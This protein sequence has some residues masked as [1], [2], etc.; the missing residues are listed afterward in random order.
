MKCPLCNA[1]TEIKDT[2][3]KKDNTVVRKRI[4]FNLHSFAT[5]ENATTK[6]RRRDDDIVEKEKND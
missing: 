6:P 4:C 5:Q 3:V 2:R 1:H